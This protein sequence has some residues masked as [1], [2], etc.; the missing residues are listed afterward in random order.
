MYELQRSENQGESPKRRKPARGLAVDW[1]WAKVNNL[2][3]GTFLKVLMASTRTKSVQDHSCAEPVKRHL[4]P[5]IMS[6][7]SIDRPK[8]QSK[9][10]D[11]SVKI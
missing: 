4:G 3:F 5:M 2:T 9:H 11:R 10:V 8:E 7:S 6:N 1:A